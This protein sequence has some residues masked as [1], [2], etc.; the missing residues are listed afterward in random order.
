VEAE[1]NPFTGMLESGQE[2]LQITKNKLRGVQDQ[3]DRSHER[4]ALYS[5]W[6]RGF[7][8]VRLQLIAEALEQL[9]IEA[10][11]ELME[12]GLIDWELRFDVDSET[13][14]GTLSRGFSVSVLS[15]HNDERVPWEA[16]SGGESQRLRIGAQCGLANLIRDR[17]GCDLPLEVWDEPTEG[18]SEEGI[19]DLMNALKERAIREGRT[20]WVVDHRSLGYGGFDGT[21]TVVKDDKGS[22]IIQSTV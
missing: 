2:R 15:P 3:L 7:K 5:F 4:H 12:L 20:I 17:T 18:L 1:K 10:N 22:R 9:E 6:V 16:W 8:E 13:K 11:S 19:T 14:K 21:V